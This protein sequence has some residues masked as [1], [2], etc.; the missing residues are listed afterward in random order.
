[1]FMGCD[2]QVELWMVLHLLFVFAE[3]FCLH[4]Y[5]YISIV[6]YYKRLFKELVPSRGISPVAAHTVRTPAKSF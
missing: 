4:V 3:T 5:E 2:H 6:G 1:M